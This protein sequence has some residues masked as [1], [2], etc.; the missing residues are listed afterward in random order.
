MKCDSWV[1]LLART[2]ANPYFDNEPKAKVVTLMMDVM[3][4]LMMSFIIF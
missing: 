1:S 2:F 4:F 3:L